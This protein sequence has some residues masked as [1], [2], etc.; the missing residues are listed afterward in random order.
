MALIAGK[1]PRKLC[2]IL[3]HHAQRFGSNYIFG[4]LVV[5]HL[6]SGPAR[7]KVHCH[8]ILMHVASEFQSHAL[9]VLFIFSGVESMRV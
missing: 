4:A 7:G 6:F 9:E 3:Y 1:T 5:N 2:S 8:T